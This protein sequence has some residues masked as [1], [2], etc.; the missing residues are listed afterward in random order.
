M[1][2][3]KGHVFFGVCL[4]A[5]LFFAQAVVGG[6]CRGMQWNSMLGFVQVGWPHSHVAV[7][8][9]VC[10]TGDNMQEINFLNTPGVINPIFKPRCTQKHTGIKLCNHL[11]SFSDTLDGSEN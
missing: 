7:R 9:L 1:E 2:D 10:F 8:S 11:F 5:V 6:R 3:H 4:D